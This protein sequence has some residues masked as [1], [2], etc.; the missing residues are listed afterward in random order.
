MWLYVLLINKA[1]ITQKSH[2]GNSMI[3]LNRNDYIKQRNEM[4]SDSSKFKKLDIKPG[5]EINS[6]L[7][8]EDR[9]TNFLQKMKRHISD[10]LFKELYPRGSQPG[11][12]YG[13]S[14]IHKRLIKNF[15]KLRSVLSVINTATYGWAKFFVP[16]I[17][18]FTNNEYSL[19]DSFKLVNHITNQSSNC[20]IA[21]L[22]VDSLCTNVPLDEN[23]NFCIDELFKSEIKV[24]G[25][26]KK[27]MFEMLP[28]SIREFYFV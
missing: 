20:F 11:I 27:G 2:K 9:L 5:K 18:C 24:S 25:L 28:L 8:K 17:K 16:L 10:Q 23:I 21:S 3:L 22:D 4:L 26:S 15:S 12:M 6:L 14:K 13:L 7:Q 1:L 19:K